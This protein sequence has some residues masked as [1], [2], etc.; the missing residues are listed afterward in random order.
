LT[1][2]A[3]R[4]GTVEGV[5]FDDQDGDGLRDPGEPGVQEMPLLLWKGDALRF[6]GTS[7]ADG[8]FSIVGDAGSHQFELTLPEGW[9]F[10]LPDQ[11]WD[12]PLTNP[13]PS[14][15]LPRWGS[16]QNLRRH[17]D[18]PD[19]LSF[20]S[21]GDSIPAG[22]NFCGDSGYIDPVMADINAITGGTAVAVNE[23]SPGAHSEDLLT[24]MLSGGGP[25]P[26]FVGNVIAGSP[27]IVA[28]N[29]G[30]NDFLDTDGNLQA[31]L[32]SL[33]DTRATTQEILSSLLI[34]LPEVDLIFNAVYDNEAEN[35]DTSDYHARATPLWTQVV[36]WQATG[37]VRAVSL[38]ELALDFA[39]QDVNRSQCA[40][41]E[42]LICMF[43]LDQI[44]PVAPGYE[45]IR[46]ATMES[47]G[48]VRIP[49]GDT[50]PGVQLGLMRRV[51]ELEPSVATVV[52]GSV[53]G[54]SDALT[55]DDRGAS[56]PPG[57]ELRLSGWSL[58]PD[59][60]PSAIVVRVRFRTS[61]DFDDDA[62]RLDASFLDFQAPATLGWTNW[63]YL[64][65]IVGG[66]GAFG[67]G[68]ALGNG[69]VN[70]VPDQPDWVEAS[71]RVTLNA[72]DDGTVTGFYSWPAPTA[73]DLANLQ[74]RLRV[75]A[76]G[77]ADAA[78]VEWDSAVVE[79]YGSGPSGV[80]G[81][82]EV[83]D[84]RSGEAPL[85]T[86][87]DPAG[88]RLSW[89]PEAGADTYRVYRGALPARTGDAAAFAAAEAGLR[90]TPETVFVDG[91]EV[92]SVFWLVSA[93]DDTGSE[94]PVGSDSADRPRETAGADCP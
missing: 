64:S 93:V 20:V 92:G 43:L 16:A 30:G 65:P 87:T 69:R 10:S 81:V 86:T 7:S 48:E 46:R 40:G 18:G 13:D 5:I 79:V 9:R 90:C 39:H 42:G 11:T 35:C 89:D 85:L 37:Q 29:I 61:G 63:D 28:I 6:P 19:E 71:A 68:Q 49:A 14:V 94:G 2:V 4:A 51:V 45:V 60:T 32:Q 25:N 57:G 17:A 84:V 67:S 74:V 21:L 15:V 59:V 76:A 33:I 50:I 47:L 75:T 53:S 23:A 78:A 41:V 55:S 1:S 54:E 38:A 52:S 8:S 56:V 72:V 12:P 34:G 77:A 24:P 27:D 3:A 26:Q 83:S 58:P 62:Y 91:D 44:H 22:F 88:R 66:S 31:N 82:G 36:R 73:E 80:P 70:A